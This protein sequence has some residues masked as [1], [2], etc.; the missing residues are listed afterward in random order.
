MMTQRQRAMTAEEAAILRPR[1]D[2][3]FGERSFVGTHVGGCLAG[4][5][6]GSMPAAV[7]A[8]I[9]GAWAL[10]TW[11]GFGLAGIGASHLI[12]RS[13]VAQAAEWRAQYVAD[14]E[15][16]SVEEIT[17]SVAGAVVF[18]I[19]E[20]IGPGCLLDFGDGN[21]LFLQG[22]HLDDGMDEN[23]FPAER[24]R[25]SR[26][27]ETRAVL[28]FEYEGEPIPVGPPLPLT[29]LKRPLE[30]GELLKG[31]LADFVSMDEDEQPG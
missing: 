19:E 8:S 7:L 5:A 1:L 25:I 2:Y 28:T 4:L 18:E 6:G 22:E 30:D 10:W 12:Y 24:V 26:A 11:A 27:L 21:L 14:L 17:G 29:A 15:A 31:Q 13:S 23:L 20:D 16:G 9:D 3:R